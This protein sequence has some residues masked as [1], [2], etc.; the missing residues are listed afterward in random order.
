[1][2]MQAMNSMENPWNGVIRVVQRQHRLWLGG[3]EPL[4]AIGNNL[5][6]VGEKLS[7]P[8]VVEFSEWVG[9]VPRFL[10]FDGVQ[11]RR[12]G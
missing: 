10:W 2:P 11:F 5:F 4:T 9:E 6:R 8:A 1:M 12:V 7:S 3:T